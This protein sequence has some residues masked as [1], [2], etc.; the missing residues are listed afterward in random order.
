MNDNPGVAPAPKPKRKTK[1][2]PKP[3]AKA[4]TSA[5]TVAG[6]GPKLPPVAE[7]RRRYFTDLSPRHAEWLDRYTAYLAMERRRPT[8]TADALEHIIR[9][10]YAVD[11]TK[12]GLLTQAKTV[13]AQI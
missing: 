13:P 2:K 1:A 4:K 8:S 11:P 12:A 6:S 10:T 9:N 7:G 5:A 3:K